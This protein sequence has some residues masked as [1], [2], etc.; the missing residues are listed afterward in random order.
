MKSDERRKKIISML[1]GR[2]EYLNASKMAEILG[3]SRQIIV[4]DI[5]LLRAKGSKIVSTPRGY[6]LEN[7]EHGYVNAVVCKH[8]KEQI[9]EEFY[10]VVDNGGAIEDV[11]IDHPIYGLISASLNIRSRFDAN[12][13]IEQ[14]ANAGA[15]PLSELTEGLH[16]H[17]ICTRNEEDFKRI[18]ISLKDLGIL[19]EE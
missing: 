13:F 16:T 18:Y 3:V 17:R 12:V 15:K 14:I 2:K 8:G 5:A 1:E 10:A 9:Q 19:I 6:V 4:S 7:D 11:S